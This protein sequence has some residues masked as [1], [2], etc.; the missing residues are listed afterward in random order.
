MYIIHLYVQNKIH[1]LE[2]ETGNPSGAPEF[3]S[4][5]CGISVA[6]SVNFCAEFCRYLFVILL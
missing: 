5:F 2:A 6:Q 3:N 1:G 4:G